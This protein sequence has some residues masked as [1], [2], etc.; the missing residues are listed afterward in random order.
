M[1]GPDPRVNFITTSNFRQ[2]F[3]SRAYHGKAS[4]NRNQ[5]LHILATY[6]RCFE[7]SVGIGDSP[8]TFMVMPL[9]LPSASVSSIRKS[10]QQGNNAPDSER[11]RVLSSVSCLLSPPPLF[12][13]RARRLDDGV[14]H[15][16]QGRKL[17]HLLRQSFR[18][19]P[20]PTPIPLSAMPSASDRRGSILNRVGSLGTD[21][22]LQGRTEGKGGLVLEYSSHFWSSE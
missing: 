19:T 7:T 22:S 17:L 9:G 20:R 13:S 4:G 14:V 6:S 18:A 16:D 2:C 10:C 12:D 5:A 1:L 8:N 21:R 15:Q 11:R 3:S